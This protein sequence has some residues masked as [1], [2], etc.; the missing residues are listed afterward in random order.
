[1]YRNYI[2]SENQQ[3]DTIICEKPD[4]FFEGVGYELVQNGFFSKWHQKITKQKNLHFIKA[5]EKIIRPGQKY[6]LQIVDNR[7]LVKDLQQHL[8]KNNQ[9]HQCYIQYFFHGYSPSGFDSNLRMYEKIDEIILLTQRSYQQFR[10]FLTIFTPR[11]SILH[12]GIDVQKFH[13]VSTEAKLELK[14]KM[15]FE[16]KK[17][18]VWCAR[19]RPKK[20]LHMVL[21]AWKLLARTHSDIVLVVIGAEPGKPQ[22]GVHYLGN[23]ANDLLPQYYQMADVYLFPTL[24]HEGFGMSLAEALHCG[25]YC[26]AS[27]LGG[28]PEVLQEGKI[29]KL[30]ENPNFVSEWVAAI[31]EYLSGNHKEYD[32]PEGLYSTE[33]WNSDMNRIIASA[34][35]CIE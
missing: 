33:K 18:F 34:K 22:D 27:A 35:L 20:G 32:I 14:R 29:G 30:I 28:V 12:N 25:C 26:I 24:C 17:V 1:M 11:V 4:Y 31:E 16:H 7:S 23:V 3:I 10:Q 21:A 6:I 19:Y 5:L 9:R 2:T 15:Q 13:R 8:E